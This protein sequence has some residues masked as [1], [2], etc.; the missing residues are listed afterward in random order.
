M[1]N[2]T[3]NF[4][5]KGTFNK[6]QNGFANDLSN[7]M[8]KLPPQSIPLEEAILGALLLEKKAFED[9]VDILKADSFYKDAHQLIFQSML[10]L[11][12]K[13]S[14]IDLL[15]VRTQLEKNGNLEIVGGAYALVRL[16]TEVSSS[17]NVVYHAHEIV[18]RAI[19]RKMI[20]VASTV[21]QN[22]FEDT[23]DAF[24]LLDETQ[25]EL[26]EITEDN[27]R[28]RTSDMASVYLT[29]LKDLEEKRKNKT[30]I[31]GIQSGFT[32]LDRITAGWQ[33]S[34]LIILA[35]R[36]GMGKCLKKDTYIVMFD[37]TLKKVQDIQVGE[38]LMG[39]DST[40]RKVLSLARGQEKMYWITQKKGIRYGV[41]ES[42][43]L[44]L[45]RSTSSKNEGKHKKGEV[46][47]I[48]V[49]DYLKK[50]DKFKSNYKGYKVAVEFAEKPV[51][52]EPYFLGMWLGD[53]HSYSSRITTQ[54]SE[55]VSYMKD[56]A[57]N[58]G[59]QLVEYQQENRCS[60]FGITKGTQG[61]QHFYS[62]QKELRILN[63]L[64]NKHIPQHYLVNSTKNRLS[65]LAGLLDSDGHYL[66]DSNGYEI[67]QKNENLA[68]QIK[69]LC[70]TL[71]FRTSLKKKKAQITR[72]NY[73]C[74]VW[75]VRIYGDIDKIP[76]KVKR[77][78]AR[79]WGSKIDW[80]VT[81]ITV[82]FDKI[83]D[84]YGFEIDGNRLFLLEDMT[85]THNTAF[86]LSALANAA[87][88]Y[89]HCVAIFSLEMSA[90]QLLTRMMSSEAEV[91]SQ[92][93]R[94]GSI[95][96][97]EWAQLIHRTTRLSAAKIFIDDTPAITM[98]ELRAK[99]RRLKSQHNLNM[100][101]ID[102]LQ[103]MSGDSG[104]G[105]GNR[106]QEIAGISRALK[107][108]AKELDVPVMAL[109]Q[110][111]RAVETRGG[112]KKPMLSDLRESGCLVA[113]TQIIE[114]H[115]GKLFTIKELADRE[116][117]TPFYCLA[118]GNDKKIRPYLM[119]K[120]FYSGIK[121]TYQLI[122]RSGKSI[123]ASANHPFLKLE[124]W[125]ALENLNVGDRIGVP[126]SKQNSKVESTEN[127]IFEIQSNY[128]HS[129]QTLLLEK[130]QVKTKIDDT[131]SDIF[132]DEIVQIIPL[133]EE[134]VFD[135]TV[136]EVHNFVAN[137]IIVHN[138]IEQ[139]ADM[140]I[141]LYRPEYY[142]ITQDDQGN[143]THGTAEVIIAKNRHGSL[144]T[145][146]LQFVGKYTKF[147]DLD[148][149]GFSA[150]NTGY[151]SGFPNAHD[152]L[153]NMP[154]DDGFTTLPSKGNNMKIDD[155]LKNKQN[156]TDFGDEPPF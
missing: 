104:K 76:V 26:F 77:K 88:K 11:S 96:D 40:P 155:D 20:G 9:V 1:D 65:L 82:E 89:D 134:H 149:G 15:T 59:L 62:L 72:I 93:L 51:T 46:L 34:D 146:R 25:S 22:A 67:T 116:K 148:E 70:D 126:R 10:E 28:K 71:G 154:M 64:E 24:E 52:I 19:K 121:Q 100:I 142:D 53:G 87:V 83:D 99:A 4:S 129:N 97:H 63:L 105:G 39:D 32:A 54:D 110:L 68:R 102:Y 118:L 38:L 3:N 43:I 124:G 109:S 45:K 132:W 101:V 112:D 119:S 128:N 147:Q 122:T 138:S 123:K 133:E 84:Y 41:N 36:P 8:G 35:A 58:L 136:P 5:K 125:T 31:T 78:K 18:E 6:K 156:N 7:E 113:E 74:D 21:R 143:P 13:G 75:R 69:F 141:F 79:A 2:K 66:V 139:D 85:V 107:Q 47:N 23:T 16:T 33:R 115:T 42:H 73:E 140:V 92:K 106:E 81:G 12:A 91:E 61:K 86:V 30:G 44:S 145:V 55:I 152:N 98:L 108:L 114:A 94:N 57:D 17:S 14:P 144:E 103:L 49:K 90:E 151:D 153:S 60:N 50:S 80:K 135:A 130:E 111:S 117:Q 48:S 150:G 29:T 127:L 95:A 56:Y 137:D 37:G 131:N 27:V 120:V